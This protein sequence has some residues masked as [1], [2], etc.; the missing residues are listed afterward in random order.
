MPLRRVNHQLSA[1]QSFTITPDVLILKCDDNTRI[2]FLLQRRERGLLVQMGSSVCSLWLNDHKHCLS[3]AASRG[4]CSNN[5]MRY[6]SDD[7]GCL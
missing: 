2:F 5:T 6:C 1:A 4:E 7:E 3:T